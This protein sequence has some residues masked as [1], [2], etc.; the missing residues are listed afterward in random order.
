MPEGELDAYFLVSEAL[1]AAYPGRAKDIETRWKTACGE[2][3]TLR[4]VLEARRSA[5]SGARYTKDALPSFIAGAAFVFLED[6]PPADDLALAALARASV[7]LR[8][9]L[10]RLDPVDDADLLVEAGR[11]R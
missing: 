4:E 2:K 11:S 9:D 8:D 7:P 1:R 6:L 3:T 5:R 10:L